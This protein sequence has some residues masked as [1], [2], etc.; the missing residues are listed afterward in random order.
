MATPNAAG[1]T[2][3]RNVDVF[4]TPDAATP[5]RQRRER[6]IAFWFTF[7]AA[8]VLT[9]V[10]LGPL[11]YSLFVS[12]TNWTLIVAGS[13][14]QLVGLA[15]YVHVLTSPN[16]WK[17]VQV[18][19]SFACSSTGLELLLSVSF[20]IMLNQQF[21]GRGFIRAL[22]LIPLVV[23]PAVVGM[24]WKLLYDDQQ[25]VFNFFLVSGG[26]PRIQWLSQDWALTSITLTDVWQWTPFLVLIVL[27][28]LNSMDLEILEAARIDGANRFQAFRF[29]I[30]PHLM[31]YLL[32]GLFFRL[33]DAMKDFDKIYLLTQGGPGNQTTTLSIYTFDT[34]FKIFEIGRTSAISWLIAG[35]TFFISCPLL[36]IL[37]RRFLTETK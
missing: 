4:L 29:I 30:L 1:S 19:V 2:K 33:L 31:P 25:G 13:E 22:A 37:R 16:F 6:Q 28:G 9:V 34:G 23:T 27:A 10:T 20:A 15:N 8:F 14:H 21:I 11:L 32:I 36:W 12:F 18:T 17:S 24:F 5:R 26:L 35:I 7:P 3:T